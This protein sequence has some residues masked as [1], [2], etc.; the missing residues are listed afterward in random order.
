MG[1]F[2]RTYGKPS[3]QLSLERARE[4]DRALGLVSAFVANK[5]V[6]FSKA[7]FGAT[8]P[9]G[10]DPLQTQTTNETQLEETVHGSDLRQRQFDVN[11]YRQPVLTQLAT[12]PW[13]YRRGIDDEETQRVCQ[14]LRRINRHRRKAE[15]QQRLS[16]R[17]Q[18]SQTENSHVI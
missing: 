4:Y 1:Y 17:D 3:E 10:G 11:A 8:T 12:E 9:E 5:K 13:T 6:K 15:R 14:A 7:L 16:R 18:E 2:R